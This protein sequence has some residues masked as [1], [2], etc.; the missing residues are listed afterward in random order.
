MDKKNQEKSNNTVRLVME[1]SNP[2]HFLCPS[3]I[4]FLQRQSLLTL[5]W[6]LLY[7]FLSNMFILPFY[8]LF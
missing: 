6:S 4:F 5:R 7:F 8:Q 1:N 2:P 3:L